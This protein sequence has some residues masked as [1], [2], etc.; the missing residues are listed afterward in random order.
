MA[1]RF[2]L[3]PAALMTYRDVISLGIHAPEI[4]AAFYQTGHRR[5]TSALS[6]QLAD[7]HLHG[8]VNSTNPDVDADFFTHLLRA[9]IHEQVLLGLR[10]RATDT[11]IR[12]AVTHAVRALLRG[13]AR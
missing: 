11:E 8:L 4:A 10:T 13:I 3:Q 5:L 1:L 6:A 7:W 2:Y 12:G 9:G